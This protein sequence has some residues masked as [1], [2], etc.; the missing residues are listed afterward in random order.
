MGLFDN[1]S[2]SPL[3]ISNPQ[4]SAVQKPDFGISLDIG[5]FSGFGQGLFPQPTFGET[6]PQTQAEWARQQFSN[7]WDQKAQNFYNNLQD[8]NS[9]P[10]KKFDATFNNAIPDYAQQ[11][12]NTVTPSLN[13]DKL[14]AGM[15]LQN[16]SNSGTKLLGGMQAD[17]AMKEI[18][19]PPDFA[20]GN[21]QSLSE[22]FLNSQVGQNSQAISQGIDTV[23]NIASMF[24]RGQ[25]T[26]NGPKGDVRAGIE[27]GWNGIADAAA[28]FGPYGKM[29]SMGMK[30]VSAVNGIQG[31][32]FGAT[33][34]MTTTDA[35]MDSPLGVLTGVGWVNQAF[36]KNAETI[37]KDSELFAE[38]GSSYGGTSAAVDS[39]LEKSGKK[40]GA[41]STNARHKANDEIREAK[42]QQ[43]VMSDI[44]DQAADR[45]AIR[46]SMSAIN[47][48]RRAF[49]M[50]GGY[51]QAAVRVGR[52]GLSLKNI[53]TAKRVVSALKFQQ[54]GKTKDPF[55][56]YLSTLPAAQRDSTDFRVRDY[57]EFN[58]KPKDFNEAI[59]K[60]MFTWQ[61]DGWHANSVAENPATGEIEFMKSS[62][63]PNHHMEVD[64]YNS[65]DGA[66]FRSRYELQK[67]EPYWKYVK[68]KPQGE[69]V[70]SYQE[71]GILEISL[72]DIP[73]EY[74]EPVSTIEEV[75][76]DSI[77]PEFK[78]GG[79]VNVIPEGALHARLHHMENAENLTKKGIPV[80]SEKENGQLEQQAE[81]ERDE[82]IFRLEVTKKLEELLKKYS[83]N[84]TSQ[85]DKDLVAIEA[86]KLLVEEILNNTQDNT[87]LI[88][89]IN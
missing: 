47:S 6:K 61:P 12:Q 77:L 27:A 45:F 52:H 79:K 25:S 11:F 16:S 36:G 20:S 66:E 86:G 70:G 24:N 82:I 69:A 57:W 15:A 50:R 59:S 19:K 81:I 26:F 87:N 76:L 44:V 5:K 71:G 58:G 51:D 37:T 64:W 88:N 9:L 1:F 8:I 35:I 28:N 40:Y 10:E 3:T 54:G 56:F 67:T 48:N 55:D 17:E 38:A 85:K 30:A 73:E 2:G 89:N 14:Q 41:F 13:E 68:R 31:A 83:D 80:V 46:N 78:E 33:D 34:G 42:R 74:L 18:A 22:K 49:A 7:I 53:M 43:N 62:S 21:K 65:D 75:T 4:F 29:V 32:I 63:H 84:E 23:G 72:S 60:G 39:A